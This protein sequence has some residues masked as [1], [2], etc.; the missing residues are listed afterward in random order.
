MSEGTMSTKMNVYA[1]RRAG[2]H[3]PIPKEDYDAILD[4]LRS[5]RLLFCWQVAYYAFHIGRYLLGLLA[6]SVVGTAVGPLAIVIVLAFTS[7]DSFVG[8]SSGLTAQNISGAIRTCFTYSVV[9]I[10]GFDAVLGRI[11]PLSETPREKMRLSVLR[12]RF[13]IADAN[14]IRVWRS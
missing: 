6:R 14:R 5:D 3:Y 1:R 9:F 4:D 7:P 11:C 10:F 8:V 2:R 13:N 12:A